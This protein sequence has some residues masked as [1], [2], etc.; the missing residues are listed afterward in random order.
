M[1]DYLGCWE[2]PCWVAADLYATSGASKNRVNETRLGTN[3][4]GSCWTPCCFLCV[5]PC[6]VTLRSSWQR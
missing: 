6:L 3:G 5:G 1:Q 2:G 4:R